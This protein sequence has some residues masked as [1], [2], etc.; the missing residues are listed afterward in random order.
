MWLLIILLAASCLSLVT[1]T[2]IGMRFVKLIKFHI[3][4]DKTHK[5]LPFFLYANLGKNK[6]ICKKKNNLMIMNK[7][8]VKWI[9]MAYFFFKLHHLNPPGLIYLTNV[10]SPLRNVILF[11]S[12]FYLRELQAF[13]PFIL[14]YQLMYTYT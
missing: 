10:E 8:M 6:H 2:F 13:F 14:F 11:S 3:N 5:M 4:T 7:L 12:P 1:N 9:Q